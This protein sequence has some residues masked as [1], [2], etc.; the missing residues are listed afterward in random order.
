M[1]GCYGITIGDF[2]VWGQLLES[3][4]TNFTEAI[5]KKPNPSIARAYEIP[6]LFVRDISCSDFWFQR[7]SEQV[8][9]R[10]IAESFVIAA[11]AGRGL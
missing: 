3:I 10:S 4:I 1:P 2:D 7:A 6:F 8:L 11:V 9:L 5:V